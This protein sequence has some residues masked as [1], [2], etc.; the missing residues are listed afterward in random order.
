MDI[1]D[2]YA[3][4]H[5]DTQLFPSL[6]NQRKLRPQI[7]K[8][9]PK[10]SLIKYKLVNNEWCE[11]NNITWIN[12]NKNINTISSCGFV[13]LIDL[14]L[15]QNKIIELQNKITQERE[16]INT[17]RIIFNEQLQQE[18]QRRRGRVFSFFYESTMLPTRP[19]NISTT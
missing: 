3:I 8:N 15:D 18:V 6:S 14:N 2:S 4:T 1:T 13:K 19:V 7:I 11:V 9:V 10:D 16:R 5:V 12:E 17:E